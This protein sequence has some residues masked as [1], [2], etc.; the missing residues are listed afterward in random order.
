MIRGVNA[1]HQ[2]CTFPSA[3]PGGDTDEGLLN[4]IICY[5]GVG[6]GGELHNSARRITD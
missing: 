5:M 4:V 2:V 1:D 3:V 6:G